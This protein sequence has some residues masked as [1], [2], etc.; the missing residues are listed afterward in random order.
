MKIK[1]ILDRI[2]DFCT[3]SPFVDETQ[4]LY[5]DF[6]KRKMFFLENNSKRIIKEI[7]IPQI[8]HQI[9][10]KDN[11]LISEEQALPIAVQK[12]LFKRECGLIDELNN[13]VE[14]N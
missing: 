4:K 14:E 11:I 9:F 13:L 8:Q 3:S 10:E 7:F 2:V 1:K 5:K 12:F 6:N